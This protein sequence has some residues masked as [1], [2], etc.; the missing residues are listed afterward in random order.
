[1]SAQIV[2][3]HCHLGFED[4]L[5]DLDAVLERARQGGVVQ[6]VVIGTAR[7][8]SSASSSLRLAENRPWLFPVV[9]V[10]PHDA[11]LAGTELVGEV[12][13]VAAQDRIV[14][15][16]EIGLDY[17]YDLSPR[18]AQVEAFRRQ[19]AVARAVGKPLVIHTREAA[20]DTLEVLREEGAS[21]VGGVIHCFT[22]DESFAREAL[23][24]GFFVSFSGIVTFKGSATLRD[25]ARFVPSDRLLV[26]TDSPFLAPVPHRGKR[27]EPAW[28]WD[29]AR[30]VADARGE[31]LEAVAELTAAN[32]RRLF[33]LPLP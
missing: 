15:V 6:M 1:M 14:A 10:H 28:V 3:S 31:P 22:E 25:V 8:A 12:E 13:R 4:F 30:A 7:E 2:D 33:R 24:L 16:G 21:S 23:D 20:R 26:E 17:H 9:G 27:N 5:D 18:D 29:T 19:I 11:R 32:A